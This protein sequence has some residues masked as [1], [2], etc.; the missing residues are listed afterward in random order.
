MNNVLAGIRYFGNIV[1]RWT[2][3]MFV[4]GEG[5]SVIG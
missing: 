5:I 2:L 4:C 3:I 1:D